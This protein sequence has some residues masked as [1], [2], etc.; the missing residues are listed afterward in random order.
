[1]NLLFVH[2]T[3]PEYRVEFFKKLN[4]RINV[5]YL[6]TKIELSQQVYGTDFNEYGNLN[7]NINYLKK[8]LKRYVQLSKFIRDKKYDY[9]II[10]PLDSLGDLLDA[11]V[12]LIQGKISNKKLLYFGEKWEAPRNKQPLLKQIKNTIQKY[13]FKLILK[14]IDMCIVAGTKSKEYFKGLGIADDKIS[15]AIDASGVNKSVVKYDL[16]EKYKLP[17]SNIVILY[18]GR[19]IKR[20]G[21]D[22]LLKAY[23]KLECNN[24]EISLV[25]CGEGPFKSECEDIARKLNLKNVFFEGAVKPKDKYTFFSQCNIFVLPSNFYQGTS[26]AWG[27]TVNEAIQCGKQVITTTAVGAA[28]DLI[29]EKTGIMIDENNISELKDALK[30]LI[31][32][33]NLGEMEIECKKMYEKCSYDNMVNGFVNAIKKI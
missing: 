3:M 10:P 29:N 26:E 27:L 4:G 24:D 8:G 9:I 14:R 11:L 5:D 30:T 28:Y 16:K 2:N 15:I 6:F 22:I 1:M 23:S 20:K 12:I 31:N 33:K 17:E 19:I 25:I 32:N 13:A 21:L 7:L 18:Y